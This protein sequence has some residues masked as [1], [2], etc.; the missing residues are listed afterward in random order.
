MSFFSCSF[1][2]FL[3][4]DF[5]HFH[6]VFV[7]LF[8]WPCLESVELPGWITY[9]SSVNLGNI[10]SLF[11]WMFFLLLSLSFASGIPITHVVV[12][13][14]VF[15]LCLRLCSFFFIF[16][17]PSWAYIISTNLSSSL[18][19]LSPLCSNLLLRCVLVRVHQRNRTH[20]HTHTQTC[21]H[22]HKKIYYRN[23]HMWLWR[24]RGPSI[25]HPQAGEPGKLVV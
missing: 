22:T 12:C 5:F 16:F 15:H 9:C 23:G 17:S 3:V 13:L 4:F 8:Y 7:G 1:Q 2:D 6:H 20:T 14:L 19:I 24:L 18:L 21:A 11:L 10:K 25:C